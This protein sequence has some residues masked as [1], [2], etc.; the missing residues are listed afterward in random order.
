MD[1][2]HHQLFSPAQLIARACASL[3][4][5]SSLLTQAATDLSSATALLNHSITPR[6]QQSKRRSLRIADPKSQTQRQTKKPTVSPYFP[7]P[8]KKPKK[9]PVPGPTI[10]PF[11]PEPFS[12][13]RPPPG[14]SFEL[15]TPEFGLIQERICESLFALVVQA[16]LWNKTKGTA[17]R[18][19]LWKLLCTYPTPEALAS[20]DPLAVQEII[21]VLG[22]Q[23]RRAQ[24]LVKLANVWVAAPPCPTRRYGRRDYPKKGDG[25]NVKDRELLAP[26]D[27]REG[28]EIGHLPG[29]G[30]YALDSYRIFGRDR[31][32]RLQDAEGV[33]PEWKRVVPSDKE[34]APYVKFKWSQEGW[35]YDILTGIK[36]KLL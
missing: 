13:E 10:S 5:G 9:K 32:R 34:L 28:W 21:R 3:E 24:C 1:D 7:E 25:R 2:A 18:P 35:E 33:E 12:R 15:Q 29:V 30:E 6:P 22:L 16:I 8:E 4:F 36:R 27:E 23:E 19:I 11:F 14:L 17:A 20:A 26:D 31:L